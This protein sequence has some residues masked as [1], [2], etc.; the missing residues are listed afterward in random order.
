MNA[1]AGQACSH[2]VD[3]R[4]AKGRLKRGLNF[5]DK[6]RDEYWAGQRITYEPFSNMEPVCP[7][8]VASETRGSWQRTVSAVTSARARPTHDAWDRVVL[9]LLINNYLFFLMR[10]TVSGAFAEFE[11]QVAHVSAA[12]SFHATT[13][14]AAVGSATA[15]TI[16]STYVFSKCLPFGAPLTEASQDGAVNTRPSFSAR[17]CK[18]EKSIFPFPLLAICPACDHDHTQ[19]WIR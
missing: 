19:A 9:K 11:R 17:S 2:A 4:L 18:L 3:R 1:T 7:I 15:H 13:E 16:T 8:H 6:A 14:R 5:A 10:V 12:R